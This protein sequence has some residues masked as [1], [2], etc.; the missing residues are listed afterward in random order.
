MQNYKCVNFFINI[1]VLSLVLLSY[2]IKRQ[3]GLI[4]C[5]FLLIFIFVYFVTYSLFILISYKK[6]YSTLIIQVL[7]VLLFLLIFKFNLSDK[8]ALLIEIPKIEKKIET[9]KQTHILEDDI[10][11]SDEYIIFA[12]EPGFLDNQQVIVYDEKDNLKNVEDGKKNIS[13][14][15]LYVIEKARDYFYLCI[16]YR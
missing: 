4:L 10:E 8:F 1:F 14:G 13:I 12:W 6:Q 2:Y 16:L 9:I 7:A 3:I 15:R 11:I 5:T